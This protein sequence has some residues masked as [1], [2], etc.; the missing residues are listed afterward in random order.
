MKVVKFGGSSLA[1]GAQFQ[2]VLDIITAD[3]DRRVVVVSAPGKR[4]DGDIK[5]TD[6]LKTYADQTIAGADTDEIMTTILAR[7]QE[8]AQH[9]SLEDNK[10]ISQIKQQ[11]VHLNRVHYPSFNHLY[12]A[13]MGHGELLNAQLLAAIMQEKG[14]P[15]NFVSPAELGL[16]VTGSPRAARLDPE[17]YH[18]INQ[19]QFDDT[20]LL[21]VPGF[22]A[23][24]NDGYAATFSRGGSDITGAILARGLQADLY[25]NFTDVS[26]I[27]SANPKIVSH[28]QPISKMTYREMRELSYAG[29]AVFHDEAIIPVIEANIPINVKNTNDPQ[30]PGT[31]IMPNHEID[32]ENP[33]TGIANDNRFAALY[34][35]RYLLNREVGFTLKILQI[36]ATYNVSYEH[37]PSGIDDMTIIFDKAQ[38]TPEIKAHIS[39]DLYAIIAP[40]ELD[41]LDDYAIIMIVGEGMQQHIGT[42]S[43]ITSALAEAGINL[44]MIN[45]GASQISTMIGVPVDRM[46]E[47]VRVIYNAVF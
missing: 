39:H 16:T 15:A 4:F 33:V 26:A 38:L 2:K 29:F 47:A 34:L 5:V 25:E 32:S 12:A 10:I 45:Q 42:F 46:N 31:M 36:L 19:Y 24:T 23:Y 22:I 14:M 17:S 27:Y 37:M 43:K 44:P 3:N 35:H 13:F 18:A 7:Y 6:L 20:S 30:A 9:F 21:I 11:L 28:P 1:T 41:W 8:I 40:D